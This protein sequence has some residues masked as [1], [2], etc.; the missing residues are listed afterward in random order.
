[1]VGHDEPVL[2]LYHIR[3]VLLLTLVPEKNAALV[4]RRVGGLPLEKTSINQPTSGSNHKKS[5]HF[6]PLPLVLVSSVQ[7]LPAPADFS[8]RAFRFPDTLL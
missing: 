3:R 2:A 7:D 5:M 4:A 8:D 1:M 6:Q